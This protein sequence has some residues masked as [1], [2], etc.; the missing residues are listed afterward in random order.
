[1]AG[2]FSEITPNRYSIHLIRRNGKTGVAV[3]HKSNIEVERSEHS[4]T[5][6]HF[7]LLECDVVKSHHLRLCVTYRHPPSRTNKLKNS[8]AEF[9]DLLV[10]IPAELLITGD[11]NFHLDNETLSDHGF[12]HVQEATHN[13]GHTLDLVITITPFIRG[14]LSVRSKW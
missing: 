3:I 9:L 5:L 14:P 7:E 4:Q 1:M 11:L 2:S 10:V 12:V 8:M 6:S 13:K